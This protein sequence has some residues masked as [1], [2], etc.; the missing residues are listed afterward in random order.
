MP[1]RTL[2]GNNR[3]REQ[4]VQGLIL[5]RLVLRYRGRIMAEIRRAMRAAASNLSRGDA[6][7]VDAAM[8]EHRR[9][10]AVILER[11]WQESGHEMAEH[12]DTTAKASQA[13]QSKQAISSIEEQERNIT[14]TEI[15]DRIMS[16][17]IRAEGGLKIT[18]ITET[19]R[20]NI[21][22]VISAGIEEGLSEKEIAKRIREI[23]PGIAG[24]RADTISRTE[25]HASANISAQ[26]TARATGINFVREWAS[27]EDGRTRP[28]HDDADGQRVGMTEPF[29]VDGEELMYPGDPNGRAANVINCRCAVLF[30]IR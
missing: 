2:T 27:S 16:D 4:R 26:A 8:A 6:V 17:W 1:A 24:S 15:A 12:I 13:Y 7:P 23:A 30:V 18:E 21:Q 3:R 28:A 14:P 9:R 5:D 19:T 25:T 11:L 22:S 20:A 10:M 29:V